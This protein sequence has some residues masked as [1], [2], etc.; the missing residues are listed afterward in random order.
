MTDRIEW[1]V[2]MLVWTGLVLTLLVMLALFAWWLF[3]KFMVLLDDASTLADRAE[4]LEFDEVELPRPAIAVLASARDI[5]EREDARKAHRSERRRVR[6]EKRMARAR[7]I[8]KADARLLDLP[9]AWYD[10]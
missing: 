3:R 7:R 8:T 10:L 4:I 6:F 1:W 2:W 9:A 5:R